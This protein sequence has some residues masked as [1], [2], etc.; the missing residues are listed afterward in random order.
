M[1]RILNEAETSARILE[2]DAFYC[3]RNSVFFHTFKR[4]TRID[5]IGCVLQR[6]YLG[7]LSDVTVVFGMRQSL[8]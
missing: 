6:V 3:E 8:T 1:L 4:S 7:T 2:E 5:D